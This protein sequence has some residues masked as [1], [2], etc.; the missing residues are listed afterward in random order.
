MIVTIALLAWIVGLPSL[1]VGVLWLTHRETRAE[2]P[3]RRR[4]G[5]AA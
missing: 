1:I 4:E 5:P 2:R 3:R